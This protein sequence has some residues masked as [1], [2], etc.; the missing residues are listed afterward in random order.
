MAENMREVHMPAQ[1]AGPMTGE[2]KLSMVKQQVT[3]QMLKAVR[4]TEKAI[5]N[6]LESLDNLK[7]SDLENIRRRRMIE[8]KKKAAKMQE[9]RHK[10][11]GT[12][13]EL[14]DEKQWFGE[15]K[16]SERTITLFYRNT[17][18]ESDKYTQILDKHICKLAP[19]HMETSLLRF[20]KINAEKSPYL[21][22]K[23]NI[24][25][26]PT[27]LCTKDNFTHGIIKF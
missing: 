13:A 9:W 10:G 17:T 25:L 22:Q 21:C 3:T 4:D 27:I 20:I 18:N 14:A 6:E 8:L 24:V 26:L 1:P 5:D 12:Y 11:H 7:K 16:Q 19:K 23:L 15:I 2:Q